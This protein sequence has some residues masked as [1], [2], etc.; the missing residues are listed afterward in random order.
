MSTHER[1]FFYKIFFSKIGRQS[2]K[3]FGF[4]IKPDMLSTKLFEKVISKR[5]KWG[6]SGEKSGEKVKL[7]YTRFWYRD[8]TCFSMHKHLMEPEG[9][10]ETRA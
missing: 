3:Q 4:E 1:D 5:Q 9:D 2:L 7:A 8:Q 10:V 6:K